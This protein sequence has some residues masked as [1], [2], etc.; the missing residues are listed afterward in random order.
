MAPLVFIQMGGTIDKGYP[1]SLK[2]YAFE[3]GDPAAVRIAERARLDGDGLVFQSVCRKDSQEVTDEDRKQLLRCVLELKDKARVD[4]MITSAQALAAGLA[5]AARDLVVVF[6]GAMLPEEFRRSDADF[7]LGFATCAAQTAPR[8]VYVAMGGRLFQHDQVSRD[9]EGRFEFLRI[10]CAVPSVFGRS[11]LSCQDIA[12][13]NKETIIAGG[14]VIAPLIEEYGVSMLRPGGWMLVR[15]VG[16]LDRG[17]GKRW[18]SVRCVNCAVQRHG[19]ERS[20]LHRAAAEAKITV[21]SSTMMNK[22]LEVIEAHWL[23]GVDYDDIE[24]V[25]HPQSIVHSAVECQDTAILMQTGWPDMRLPILY[26]LSH[27]SR[28]PADL[29]NPRDGRNF[30]DWWI[31]DG[32]D[33]KL[34]FGKPDLEKYPCIR[35]AYRAGRIGGTMPAILSAANEQAVELLLTKEIDFLDIPAV[36]EKVMDKASPMHEIRWTWSDANLLKRGLASAGLA[37]HCSRSAEEVLRKLENLKPKDR[38]RPLRFDIHESLGRWKQASLKRAIEFLQT[39]VDEETLKARQ[40]QL[41]RSPPLPVESTTATLTAAPEAPAAVTARAARRGARARCCARGHMI[42]RKGEAFGLFQD[43][44]I[45]HACCTTFGPETSYY[46]CMQNCKY[47]V[48]HHC[49]QEARHSEAQQMLEGQ[50][51][52]SCQ[53]SHSDVESVLEFEVHGGLRSELWP[54]AESRSRPFAAQLEELAEVFEVPHG[55]LLH[56]QGSEVEVIQSIL[57]LQALPRTASLALEA[58]QQLLQQLLGQMS[59]SPDALRH[60]VS[61]LCATEALAA[62]AFRQH[63]LSPQSRSVCRSSSSLRRP[64][65][66]CRKG[67]AAAPVQRK[68]GSE[69]AL[70][71]VCRSISELRWLH[72]RHHVKNNQMGMSRRWGEMCLSFFERAVPFRAAKLSSCNVGSS[73]RSN[74]EG[75][76]EKTLQKIV[77]DGWDSTDW[78]DGQ[79]LL[80]FLCQHGDAQTVRL[81]AELCPDLEA[82][83]GQDLRA[84]DYALSNSDASEPGTEDGPDGNIGVPLTG[85]LVGYLIGILTST[86]YGFFLGYLGLKPYVLMA[87]GSISRLPEVLLLPMGILCDSERKIAW[88]LVAAA[89]FMSCVRPLPDPYYCLGE[90]GN[91]DFHSEPCNPSAHEATMWYGGSLVLISLGGAL[92]Q[93][94]GEGLLISYSQREPLHCRQL[95][96]NLTVAFFM[97]SKEYLGTFDWGLGYDGTPVGSTQGSV[98][99][100]RRIYTGLGGEAR[101]LQMGDVG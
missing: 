91:F 65:G 3:I 53:E 25:I 75:I 51:E 18:T 80:H 62:E 29:P 1:R 33:G 49:F 48:C 2:G 5:A 81:A 56:S 10:S 46:R 79:N 63:S 90:D 45:C 36:L 40:V 32:K 59:S 15:M 27:P 35:L 84:M 69:R 73:S 93:V 89:L 82:R 42:A 9:E 88:S 72:L 47:N 61:I 22:G 77:E 44:K 39:M 34:T 37:W 74:A 96:A 94:S 20:L 8:G 7:N 55:V 67:T 68:R 66:L 70:P 6:T 11:A 31:G 76:G 14:P 28:V 64:S 101:I 98:E 43:K 86:R 83:D 60:L 38:R 41:Q 21:D 97:N 57:Q 95:I 99:G 19:E 16:R 54:F 92:A 100:P 78:P 4:T 12:L 24:V 71:P 26:A 13:A 85:F 17:V 30:D 58:P 50:S 23:Y 52:P 87:I